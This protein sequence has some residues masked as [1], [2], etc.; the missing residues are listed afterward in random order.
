MGKMG[1]IMVPFNYDCHLEVA[2]IIKNDNSI[3]PK[4]TLCCSSERVGRPC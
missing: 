4:Q 2:K 1:Q 3:S